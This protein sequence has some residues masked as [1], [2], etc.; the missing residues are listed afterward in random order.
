MVVK[1][2][3]LAL[4]DKDKSFFLSKVGHLQLLENKIQSLMCYL[5]R[6][7]IEDD[8]SKC[9]ASVSISSIFPLPNHSSRMFFRD[10]TNDAKKSL[11]PLG[12]MRPVGSVPQVKNR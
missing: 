11:K 5:H 7:Y 3:L 10:I 4:H 8:L 12:H 2:F 1:A 9:S 6:E